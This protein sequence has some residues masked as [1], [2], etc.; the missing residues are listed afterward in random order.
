MDW[1]NKRKV[2]SGCEANARDLLSSRFNVDR[3]YLTSDDVLIDKPFYVSDF[4]F[5]PDFAVGST[6]FRV[7]HFEQDFSKVD[8]CCWSKLPL[9]NNRSRTIGTEQLIARDSMSAKT[10]STTELRYTGTASHSPQRRI[11]QT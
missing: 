4:G 6:E 5:D 9:T 8:N 2:S 10:S 11:T 3:K 7:S 1:N